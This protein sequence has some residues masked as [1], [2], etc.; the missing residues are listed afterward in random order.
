MTTKFT[1]YYKDDS[2]VAYGQ[3]IVPEASVMVKFNVGQP[4][5]ALL[6]LDKIKQGFSYVQS[7]TNSSLLQYGD[8]PGY[9]QFRT[10]L[11]KFLTK[12]YNEHVNDNELFVTNGNTHAV[13]FICSLFLPKGF[14]V[15]VEEPTYFLAINIFKELGLNIVSIPILSDGI[16]LDFLAKE[17]EKSDDTKYHMLYTIP[18]FHN[19]TS[20][21]MSHEKRLKLA[22]LTNRYNKF[23]IMADEVYQLLYFDEKHKPPMPLCY[24]TPKAFSMGSFSK[25]LAPGLRLGWIQIKNPDM[26]SKLIKSGQYDSSGGSSPV[27]QAIVHGVIG[28]GKLDEYLI[29]CRN[30]LGRNCFYMAEKINQK[31]SKYVDFVVPGGGYFIW[32]K[33]KDEVNIDI[34]LLMKFSEEYKVTFAPGYRFSANGDCKKN[35]RL[36]FSYYDRDGISIGIDRLEELFDDVYELSNKH[37]IAVVGYKGKLGSKI[38]SAIQNSDDFMLAE[39]INRD[40]ALKYVDM[41]SA[42]IDVSRPEGTEQ[43]I[44]TLLE[45]KK[46]VPLIIGTTGNLPMDLIKEYAKYTPVSIVSNFSCGIPQLLHLMKQM[47]TEGWDVSM[48]E[49]HHIH[50]VDAPSGTALSLEKALCKKVPIESVRE[51][52]IIGDH[53]VTFERPDEKIVIEHHAKNRDLF[54]NGALRYCGWIMKQKLGL[55]YGMEKPQLKFSQYFVDGMNYV[56]IEKNAFDKYNMKMKDLVTKYFSRTCGIVLIDV[57]PECVLSELYNHNGEMCDLYPNGLNVMF[58]YIV[59]NEFK[60]SDNIVCNVN[61]WK[62]PIIYDE[63]TQKFWHLVQNNLGQKN[64][65]TIVINHDEFDEFVMID[66]DTESYIVFRMNECSEQNLAKCVKVAKQYNNDRNIVVF[67]KNN[68]KYFVRTYDKNTENEVMECENSCYAVALFSAMM[69]ENVKHNFDLEMIQPKSGKTN[70]F[71]ICSDNDNCNIYRHGYAE[72]GYDGNIL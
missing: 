45:R 66:I 15:Y 24:Y 59:D 6:P 55:Y 68:E 17:L 40:F 35:L 19:P 63:K 27:T 47:N 28:Q 65:S 26:M 41:Y 33:I 39:G 13:S 29:E 8:I 49:R 10:C 16:D 23:Y 18:T 37:R 32:L 50:K 4:S 62:I 12:Q 72:K 2:N 54:A 69:S 34:D 48:V 22:E 61:N 60:I 67:S 11:S 14:T 21:T 1:D 57:K 58:Q 52:E 38:V 7:V 51:G 30:F 53:V 64:M 31:L 70:V 42:I 5:P 56:V 25:I 44:M 36:S 46:Y 43:L 3:Y 20:Y 71:R 9:K